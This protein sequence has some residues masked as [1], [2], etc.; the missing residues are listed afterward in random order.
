[1]T[2]LRQMM[3]EKRQCR[4]YAQ[5]TAKTYIRIVRDFAKHYNTAPDLLVPTINLCIL[6]VSVAPMLWVDRAC[7]K[8]DARVKI[9]GD[10]Q[11]EHR[12]LNGEQQE[13]APP[14]R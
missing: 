9:N 4:N 13:V 7:L 8:R 2:H 3:L 11:R 6:L 1:M 14:N 12:C 5:N 10:K